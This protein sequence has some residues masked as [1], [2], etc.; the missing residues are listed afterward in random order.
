MKQKKK[1]RDLESKIKMLGLKSFQEG[2]DG[3]GISEQLLV[4]RTQC[5]ETTSD[6]AAA[7]FLRLK[8]NYYDQGEKPGRPTAWRVKQQQTERTITAIEDA[9]RNST[10][11]PLVLKSFDSH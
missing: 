10:V 11:N 2:L 4:L 7:N 6:K 9:S 3:N 8:Q 1:L 5:D